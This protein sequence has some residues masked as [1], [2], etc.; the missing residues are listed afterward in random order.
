MKKFQH[1]VG[2]W[3]VLFLVCAIGLGIAA[4]QLW[5]KLTKVQHVFY[6]TILTKP[7]P[8]PAFTLEGTEG[9]AIDSQNLKGHWTYLFFG[10]THCASVCPVTMAELAKMYRLILQHPDLPPPLVVMVTLDP[11]RDDIVRMKDYV[12]SFNP[13]FI[14]A[15]GGQREIQNLARYLGVAYTHV[16]SSAQ[17]RTNDY[18]IEHT[19]AVMLL[20]P[21]GELVAF[22]TPPHQADGLVHDYQYLVSSLK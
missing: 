22:F 1:R 14:G 20:N 5:T 21:H 4:Q 9:Y 18:S 12:R 7:R 11:K 16:K 10:F 2:L 8:M 3:R 17:K 13:H 19:G 15:S 6:G